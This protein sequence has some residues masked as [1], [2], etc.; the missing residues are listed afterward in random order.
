MLTPPLNAKIA[1]EHVFCSMFGLR[2]S[3]CV[4]SV[5]VKPRPLR[6]AGFASGLAIVSVSWATPLT[7]VSLG[8]NDALIVGGALTASVADALRPGPDSFAAI[9]PDESVCDPGAV[10][11]TVTENVHCAPAVNAAPDRLIADPP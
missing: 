4:G 9:G 7:A 10:P 3:S 6:P 2:T 11:V 1:P 8:S 5:A